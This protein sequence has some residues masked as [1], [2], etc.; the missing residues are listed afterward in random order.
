MKE[1]DFDAL[2]DG[3]L[4]EDAAA[5]P[6]VGFEARLVAGVKAGAERESGRWWRRGWLLVPVAACAG[7][8]A[9]VW[10]GA[11]RS[12]VRDHE[13]VVER[14]ISRAA[15]SG[16][17]TAAAKAEVA[18]SR[19]RGD[20]AVAKMGHTVSAGDERAVRKM[21]RPVLVAYGSSGSKPL[22]KLDVFPSPAPVSVFPTPV[23]AEDRR[24]IPAELDAK[25]AEALQSLKQQQNEP[26]QVTAIRIPP[27]AWRQDAD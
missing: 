1:R 5:E 16:V 6:R 19:L 22:P 20:E 17:D 9:V 27:V 23:R 4:R 18:E 10:Y 12:H 14:P 8:I 7:V 26:V 21:G 25:A 11:V 24:A 15:S 3:V 2:L 13:A